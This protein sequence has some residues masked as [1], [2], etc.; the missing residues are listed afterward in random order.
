MSTSPTRPRRTAVHRVPTSL[1][2]IAVHEFA[3]DRPG[4][5]T[6][7]LWHSMFTDSRSWA[8][9][10]PLLTPR[11]RLLV[12]DGPGYGQSSPLAGRASIAACAGVA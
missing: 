4:A 6:A 1:G 7:L 12:V 3:A 2:T 8:P 5:P 9:V 10:V 11:R